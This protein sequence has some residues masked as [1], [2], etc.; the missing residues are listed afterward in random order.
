MVNVKKEGCT[1]YS[2]KVSFKDSGEQRVAYVDDTTDHLNLFDRSARYTDISITKVS[3]TVEQA[4]RLEAI[5]SED[6]ELAEL[7]SSQVNDYIQYGYVKNSEVPVVGK[8]YEDSIET[9]KRHLLNKISE[10]VAEHRYNKEVNGANYGTYIVKTDRESQATIT[11]TVVALQAGLVSNVEFKFQN[12][13][14]T[15]DTTEFF[16][17][18]TIIS[19]HVNNCFKA[20]NTTLTT[21][22]NLPLEELIPIVYPEY[23]MGMLNGEELVEEQT[24]QEDVLDPIEM[25]ESNYQSYYN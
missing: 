8:F 12:G 1:F 9:S 15:L 13:W 23:N 16:N 7:W 22:G 14:K 25:F 20:E 10:K 19:G 18:A 4:S 6:L 17:V 2:T 5:N 11:S 21:L 24:A 3:P